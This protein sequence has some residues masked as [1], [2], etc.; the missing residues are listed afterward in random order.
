VTLRQ[1]DYPTFLDALVRTKQVIV[2]AG[3]GGVGKTTT[4]AALGLA[5]AMAG[6]RVLV[7][8][9]DPA[10]R[11]AEAMG[12]PESGRTPA[13]VDRAL[14]EVAGAPSIGELSAWMLDPA[15]VL[16]DMV[17][18]WADSEEAAARIL[19][20][21]VYVALSRL[22]AGMQEY[23]AAE[24][25][26]SLVST[27]DYDL[28]VLDTPPSRN[29]IA[30]LDGP[31]KLAGFLDERIIGLFLPGKGG[32]LWKR[33]TQL[34]SIVFGRAFGDGFFHDLQEFLGLFAGMFSRMREHATH[35]RTILQSQATAYV[36]VTSPEPAALAEVAFFREQIREKGLPF[37]GYVLN[38]SWAFTRGF[39]NPTGIPAPDNAPAC[40]AEAARKLQVLAEEELVRAVRDRSLLE[41]LRDRSGGAFATASPHLGEGIEDLRGLVDLARCLVLPSAARG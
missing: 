30:F 36:L 40:A 2:C 35:V 10:R 28:V 7:L 15:V 21:K 19:S 11:L 33:A 22:V 13:R 41:R 18:R 39:K 26:H 27:G 29:A 32:A 6:R 24:A 4:S 34:V 5:G 17:R 16:E 8:T 23:T 1:S 31:G 25:L 12:I 3:A 14:L 20:N 38:R 37:A 9:I